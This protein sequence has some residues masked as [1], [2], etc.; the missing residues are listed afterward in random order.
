MAAGLNEMADARSQ[1]SKDLSE[2]A[3][4]N[5]S[6]AD[7][8]ERLEKKLEPVRISRP[9]PALNEALSKIAEPYRSAIADR[10]HE[11]NCGL[12][13]LHDRLS[14]LLNEVDL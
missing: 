14:Q 5:G 2:Q 1:L 8:V 3:R 6:L 4:L 9:E 10:V 11:N 13:Q 7:L 12:T